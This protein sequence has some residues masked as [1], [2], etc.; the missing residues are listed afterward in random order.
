[1][2]S[3]LISPFYVENGQ[4]LNF[5]KNY[6]IQFGSVEV[7]IVLSQDDQ[8]ADA[9]REYEKEML[10]MTQLHHPNIVK[11][12]GLCTDSP[13]YYILTEYMENGNLAEYLQDM[14][15]SKTGTLTLEDKIHICVQIASGNTTRISIKLTA[16]IKFLFPGIYFSQF[17]SRISTDTIKTESL[18]TVPSI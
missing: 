11:L 18:L 14:A 9:I 10:M 8:S 16:N 17:S 3:L 5:H 1:M 4:L 12:V 13:P 7:Y 2:K 6:W 15:Q